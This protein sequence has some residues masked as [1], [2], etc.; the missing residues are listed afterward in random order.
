MKKS[1]LSQI[2]QEKERAKGDIKDIIEIVDDR[3]KFE[4]VLPYLKIEKLISETGELFFDKKIIAN[5]EAIKKYNSG[6]DSWEQ[7]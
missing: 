7:K 5:D 4:R 2:W 3:C 6:L 1:R